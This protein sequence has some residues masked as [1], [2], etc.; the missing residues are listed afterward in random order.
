MGRKQSSRTEFSASSRSACKAL[1]SRS[2]L[3]LE[4]TSLQHQAGTLASAEGMEKLGSSPLSLSSEATQRA[5]NPQPEETWS[6]SQQWVEAFS[7]RASG[8][9]SVCSVRLCGKAPVC[10]M[11]PCLLLLWGTGRL[12]PTHSLACSA[13]AGSSVAQGKLGL[14][15]LTAASAPS[16]LR[17]DTE[18]GSSH[19]LCSLL[20]SATPD[21]CLPTLTSLLWFPGLLL[22]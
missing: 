22:S 13:S 17:Q 10:S 2:L 15:L 8:A 4:L 20:L 16:Q 1:W 12:C 14:Q 6:D 7:C 5:A 19:S 11:E 3:S 21:F 18:P 9:K